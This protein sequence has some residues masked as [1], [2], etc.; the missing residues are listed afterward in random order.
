MLAMRENFGHVVECGCGTVHVT[1]GP[2]TVALDSES[3]RKL[4]N[5]LG[6]AIE[7]VER[8]EIGA[9]L[10]EAK[11][12]LAHGSHLAIKKVLKIKH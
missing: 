8:N 4:H 7:S 6:Q 1:I 11:P 12:L 9:E 2:V 10:P 5:M 3:L